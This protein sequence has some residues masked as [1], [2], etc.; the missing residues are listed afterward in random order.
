[1]QTAVI[2]TADL[3]VRQSVRP[4]VTFR[5]V[6]VFVQTNEDTIVRSSV[7]GRTII[8]VSGAVIVYTDIRRGSNPARAL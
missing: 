6:P 4:S 1:M 5:R 3:S 2:A 8:L 7:P